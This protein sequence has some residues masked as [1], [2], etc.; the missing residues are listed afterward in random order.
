MAIIG[1]C[2]CCARQIIIKLLLRHEENEIW[3]MKWLP[4]LK[5][6]LGVTPE[7]ASYPRNMKTRLPSSALKGQG[8]IKNYLL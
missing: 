4:R 7:A 6:L 3:L 5:F 1:C 8:S 2:C